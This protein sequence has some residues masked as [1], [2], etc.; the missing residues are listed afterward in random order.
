MRAPEMAAIMTIPARRP[1]K[2]V[3]VRNLVMFI[4]HV[5][6]VRKDK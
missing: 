4:E 1:I 5:H 2:P 6:E 3:Y